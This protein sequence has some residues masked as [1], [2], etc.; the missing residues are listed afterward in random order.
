MSAPEEITPAE[1]ERRREEFHVVDV[2]A[3][4]EY[5]GPLGHVRG[6][7]LVPLPELEAR[8]KEIPA[9][10]P[11]LLVC[12]SGVRS[13]KACERLQALGIGP[14]VNLVGGMIA[15]NRAALP[16]ERVQPGSLGELLES[17]VLWMA[18]VGA[19]APDAARATFRTAL[20][21]SGLSFDAPTRAS[22]E[23]V[24][25]TVEESQRANPPPDQDLS[26]AAFRRALAAL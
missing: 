18:Q 7:Q 5:R 23:R 2:R 25:E 19:L 16:T 14:T 8:A 26:L 10:R 20:A 9:G 12:R 21:A 4:H 22:I 24:L 15:W 11:L 13:A 17:I 3:D 6:A 1:A